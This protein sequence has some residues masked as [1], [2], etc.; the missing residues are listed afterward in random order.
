MKIFFFL[1]SAQFV[2]ETTNKRYGF[3]DELECRTKEDALELVEAILR[4]R[5]KKEFGSDRGKFTYNFCQRTVYVN[6]EKVE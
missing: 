4:G 1:V 2:E 5:A 3:L 6:G